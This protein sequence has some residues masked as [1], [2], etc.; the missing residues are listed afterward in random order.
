MAKVVV[1]DN[2]FE[3]GRREREISE[4]VVLPETRRRRRRLSLL[5][6]SG[7]EAG[8]R[9]CLCFLGLR[10]IQVT[11]VIQRLVRLHPMYDSV[12]HK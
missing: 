1:S 7:F 3:A 11:I 6:D 8:R 5:L 2:R 4:L 10:G 9:K 12:R